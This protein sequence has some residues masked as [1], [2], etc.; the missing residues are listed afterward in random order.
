MTGVPKKDM[1]LKEES[2]VRVPDETC[3]VAV[4]GGGVGGLSAAA[5]LA[6]AGLDVQLFEANERV[7]GCLVGFDRGGF[8]FDTAI[9]WLNFFAPGGVVRHLL[10]YVGGDFPETR[11]P[12]IYRRYRS[13]DRDYRLTAD[14]RELEA[15]LVRDFP[16]E[17]RG[18]RSF[19]DAA[20]KVGESFLVF[21]NRMRAPSTMGPIEKLVA[22]VSIGRNSLPLWRYSGK[23]AEKGL[24]GFFR[25]PDLRQI[26]CS[27]ELLIACLMPIGWVFTDN[28]HLSPAGGS[29]RIAEFL[30]EAAA[31][32]GAAIHTGM[33]VERVNVDRRRCVGVSVRPSAGGEPIRVRS[34]YVVCCS[35]LHDLLERFLPDSAATRAYAGKLDKADLYDS[36]VTISLGLDLPSSKVGFDD[37]LTFLSDPGRPSAQYRQCDPDVSLITALSSSASDATLAPVDKGTLTVFVPADISYCDNWRCGPG[38]ARGT[39]YQ[40]LKEEFSQRVLERVERG[41]APNLRRH[42]E[43]M[44]VATPVTYQRYTQNRNGTMMGQ[45]PTRKNI[46]SRLAGYR[47]PIENLL[48]GGHWA[49]YGG[50][51]PAVVRAAANSTAMIL[52]KENPD[53]FRGLV[54]AL[55]NR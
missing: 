19:F 28:Y 31:R 41:L 53:A 35:D 12:N 51:V 18:I 46:Y 47:T 17:E 1:K 21:G 43:V 44:D 6:K 16:A 29:R 32:H 36:S 24:D 42:I 48:L 30:K 54:R 37:G 13:G 27:E 15:Q 49:E 39:A 5:F 7:G 38:F 52:R 2:S 50:G 33:R 3:D 20:K 9:H 34:R 45:R 26:F 10:E 55:D 4:I 8:H 23:S 11:A 22:G 14:P 40:E 25:H